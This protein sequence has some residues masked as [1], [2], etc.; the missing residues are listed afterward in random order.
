M[1]LNRCYPLDY[2]LRYHYR[3]AGGR[4]LAREQHA[5]FDLLKIPLFGREEDAADQYSAYIM[6]HFGKEDT[7]RLIEGSAYQ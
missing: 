7:H 1:P 6:L 2:P 3:T 5:V 4:F